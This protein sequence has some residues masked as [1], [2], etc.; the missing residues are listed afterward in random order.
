MG[1]HFTCA[2]L[3]YLFASCRG[4]SLP[5]QVRVPASRFPLETSARR[6]SPLGCLPR[7]LSPLGPSVA[8]PRPSAPLPLKMSNT[9]FSRKPRFSRKEHTSSGSQFRRSLL[10]ESG[11]ADWFAP[12]GGVLCGVLG[13][14]SQRGRLAGCSKPALCMAT[15]DTRRSEVKYRGIRSRAAALT[16]QPRGRVHSVLP[17]SRPTAQARWTSAPG[18]WPPWGASAWPI[19]Q[20]QCLYDR[21]QLRP[22]VSPKGRSY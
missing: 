1:V 21:P 11:S 9:F 5:T 18:A 2:H 20:A 13:L 10:W 8:I 16:P 17:V 6:A 19:A 14:P 22:C 12:A 3:G 4:A 7:G 15:S